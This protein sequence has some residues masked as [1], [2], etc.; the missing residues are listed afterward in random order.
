MFV[1]ARRGT[2]RAR[3]RSGIRT[4]RGR[5]TRTPPSWRRLGCSSMC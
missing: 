1:Q 5:A 3:R 4:P 2:L